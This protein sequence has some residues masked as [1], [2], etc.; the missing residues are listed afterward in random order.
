M[1]ID[2][3]VTDWRVSQVTGTGGGT[4]IRHGSNIYLAPSGVQKE[5]MKPTDLFVMD[6]ESEKYLRRPEVCF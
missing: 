1:R 2:G 6:F 3:T 4:S 5:L